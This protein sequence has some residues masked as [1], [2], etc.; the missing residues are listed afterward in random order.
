MS[1]NTAFV[2]F[3]LQTLT[4]SPLPTYF[5]RLLSSIHHNQA[6]P[7]K[8][9]QLV[10][11]SKGKATA[12]QIHARMPCTQLPVFLPPSPPLPS[13]PLSPTQ[14]PSSFKDKEKPREIRLSN[15]IAAKGKSA[16]IREGG[17][18]GERVGEKG[19]IEG[20]NAGFVGDLIHPSPLS[21]H[22]SVRPSV[23]PFMH[24]LFLFRNSPPIHSFL[25]P[26]FTPSIPPAVSD[27]VRTSLG[28]KGMDKMVQFWCLILVIV[29]FVCQLTPL[30]L[31]LSLSLH[32][33]IQS[34]NGDV[35]I[36][37]DGATILKNMQVMHPAGRMV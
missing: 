14:L 8:Q 12:D 20:R 6:C 13:L 9:Q 25:S 23:R 26:Y 11:A 36:S 1:F 7:E 4:K 33:K 10:E 3:P 2:A 5:S 18:E 30:C 19:E 31:S 35:L 29:F 28:P 24:L 27:A 15:I 16:Q 37:N 17:R 22:P 34:G 32:K 21:I